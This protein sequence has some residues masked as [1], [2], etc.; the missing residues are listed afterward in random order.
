MNKNENWQKRAK[1]FK[2]VKYGSPSTSWTKGLE[3]RINLAKKYLIFKNQK[4][5]DVGCG[6]GM[7]LERF[8]KEGAYVY[9]IDVDKDKVNIAYKKYKN[10]KVS[11]AEKIS[12]N[13]NT[14]DI[15]WLH[16]VIEHVENDK[17]VIGEC[18][19]VLKN[20]GKLVIFA[21]NR[22]WPFETHGIFWADKYIFGNIP[23]VTYFPNTIYKEMT[24]H[25]RNYYKKDLLNL[26]A[27]KSYKIVTYKGI[28]PRFDKITYKYGIIGK[29]LRM[30]FILAEKTPLNAF[31]ISHFLIVEKV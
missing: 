14:F 23:L 30:I 28:F 21:P 15:V 25:V 18:F 9:G 17:K 11:P 5:L 6:V 13:K 27:D 19:R 24:P 22:L 7:F 16:E 26:I 4:V 12:Y 3:D 31:G 8:K 20:H 10:V 29:I 2:Q 1:T